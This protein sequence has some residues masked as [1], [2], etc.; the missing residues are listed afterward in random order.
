MF[1]LIVIAISIVLVAVLAAATL[2]YG[3]TQFLHGQTNAKAAQVVNESSQIQGAVQAWKLNNGDNLPSSMSDLVNYGYLNGVP[4][5]SWSFAT[6]SVQSQILDQPACLQA[7]TML[8][9]NFS[10]VPGCS[11]YPN[12]TICC[13]PAS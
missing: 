7:D 11:A 2:W 9:Y 12:V 1:T 8:G 5:A 10:T 3:G 4:S 6:D 13:D